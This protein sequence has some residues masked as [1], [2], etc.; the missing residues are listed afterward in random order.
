[1]RKKIWALVPQITF[2]RADTRI[3]NVHSFARPFFFLKH[4]VDVPGMKEVEKD[5]TKSK[6]AVSDMWNEAKAELSR[7]E[8]NGNLD[9]ADAIKGIQEKHCNELKKLAKKFETRG[10]TIRVP[11]N[12]A[13]RNHLQ[14]LKRYFEIQL[15]AVN[16]CLEHA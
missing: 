3:N 7:A 11:N 1:M 10:A 5:L 9:C 8:S 15:A 4:D 2:F 6:K 13:E 14:Q 12:Q 16:T